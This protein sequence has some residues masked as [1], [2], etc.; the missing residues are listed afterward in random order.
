[1]VVYGTSSQKDSAGSLKLLR[2]TKAVYLVESRHFRS[3]KIA[4]LTEEVGT[5]KVVEN[6]NIKATIE[7]AVRQ[8]E[9]GDTILIVGSFYIMGEARRHL[10]YDDEFDPEELNWSK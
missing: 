10:G 4:Q 3:K 8:G 7:E 1:M 9:P 6:G 2:G 5:E